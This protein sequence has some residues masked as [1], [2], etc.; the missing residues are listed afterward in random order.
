MDA[1]R[2]IV[3]FRSSR[4]TPVL[5][6]ESQVN[7]QVYGAELAYWLCSQL[8][9]RGVITSYPI[10]EDWGWF[11]EYITDTGSEFAIHCGN[12][13]GAK[14]HWLLSLRR[15]GRKMFGRDKPPY[16]EA[17]PVI[18]GIRAL[19]NGV[20]DLSSVQWLYEDAAPVR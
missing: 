14:D 10:N 5:P 8:A 1:L 4:F 15:H 18:D 20:S 2:D 11:I 6:E 12:V 17:A 16:S 9:K 7:P 3:E 13:G 19:V